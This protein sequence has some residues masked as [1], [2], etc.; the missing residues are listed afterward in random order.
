MPRKHCF[1]LTRKPRTPRRRTTT[2]AAEG[3]RSAFALSHRS[4]T[5]VV[6]ENEEGLRESDEKDHV[7]NEEAKHIVDKHLVDHH[8]ERASQ[9]EGHDE[10]QHVAPADKRC[11]G[12]NG[13]LGLHVE[14]AQNV[15]ND[16][17]KAERT[18][19]TILQ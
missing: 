12:Q 5:V 11:D 9:P 13:H 17:A 19:E 4:L 2:T 1:T 10:E 7:D 6:E 15:R 18:R 16:D 14:Y 3:D 8:H